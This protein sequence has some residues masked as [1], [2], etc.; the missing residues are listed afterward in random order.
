MGTDRVGPE[1]LDAVVPNLKRLGLLT[2]RVREKFAQLNILSY[3]TMP[4][5]TQEDETAVPPALL[6]LFLQL[7]AA[8]ANLTPPSAN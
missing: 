6:Q 2:P 8:G 5:S 3:E 4:D 1:D 7:Q